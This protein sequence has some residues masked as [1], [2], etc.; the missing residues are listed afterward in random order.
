M[1]AEYHNITEAEMNEFLAPQG[2]KKI[3]IPGT[4]EIV[5]AKRVDQGKN[6]LSLRVNTGINPSGQSRGVG[7]DA[8]R[9]VLFLRDETGK[10]TK[11]AGSKR[12][13]RV[14]NWKQNLQTRLDG[15]LELLPKD[16]CPACG[17]PMLPRKG[18]NGSFLG[19][20][21]YP[22]CRKTLPIKEV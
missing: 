20:C 5:Y 16:S 6:Q 17:S 2:F 10:I 13:H 19:C 14:K 11:L 9:I 15:W 3:V 4:Y 18:P 7:E 22:E 12:V 21:R 1:A 8:M